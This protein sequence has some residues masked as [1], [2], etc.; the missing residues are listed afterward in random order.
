MENPAIKSAPDDRLDE[1]L[2]GLRVL[3]GPTISNYR[4]EE[5]VRGVGAFMRRSISYWLRPFRAQTL[6]VFASDQ[7]QACSDSN[8]SARHFILNS[9]PIICTLHEVEE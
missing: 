5:L 3:S 9:I 4:S 7:Q 8:R 2:K 1:G 6:A